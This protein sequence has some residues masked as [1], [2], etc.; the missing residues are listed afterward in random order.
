MKLCSKSQQN[1]PLQTPTMKKSLYIILFFSLVFTTEGFSVALTWVGIGSGGAGTNFN[2]AANWSP[3][4]V[5]T[6]ADAL[7]I[8]M[9]VGTNNIISLSGNIT[10][11]SLTMSVSGGRQGRLR[12]NGFLLTVN[13]AASFNAVNYTSPASYSFCEVDAGNAPGGFVFNGATQIHTTGSGDT[14]IGGATVSEGTMTFN[15]SL[16]MGPWAYTN[17]G[18][19]PIFAFDAVGAQTVTYRSNYHIK[20]SSMRFGVVNSPTVTIVAVAPGVAPNNFFTIYDGSVILNNNSL[21]DIGNF[22]FDPWVGGAGIQVNSTSTLQIGDNNNFPGFGVATANPTNYATYTISSVSR[23]SYVGGLAQSISNLAN[24]GYGHILFSGAGAKTSA[25]SFS[26]RGNWNN[27]TTF[28][29]N[30][31]THTFNGTPNQSIGG[32]VA[33]I[34]YNLIE[35]KA[36][37]S[38]LMAINNNQVNNV[39]TLTA[40]PLD[41]SGFTLIVNNAALAAVVRTAGYIISETNTAANA[42]IV[43][44]NMGVTTGAFVFP[45]GTTGAVYIPFTFNK[46]TATASNVSISTRPNVTSANTPWATGVTHMFSPTLAQDGSDEAV[47]DR[48]WHITSSAASTANLTFT[49]RGAENTMSV[50][51]NTGNVGAQYWG[52]AAWLPN[53]SNIG[54][55]PAVTAGTGSVTA[56]GVVFTA[57][58]FTPMVLSSTGAPL[59]VELVSF[60][61]TCIGDFA[62]L[63]WVTASETNNSHFDILRSDNGEPFHVVGTVDGN[64]TTSLSSE[65]KFIDEQSLGTSTMYRLVQYD[66][67]GDSKVFAPISV[68]SCATGNS[69]VHTYASNEELVVLIDSKAEGVFTVSIVDMQGRTV[70]AQQLTAGEGS[71][72]FGISKEGIVPGIYLV[73]TTLPNGEV[74][75]EK[76]FVQ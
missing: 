2:A 12:A 60:T 4:Q 65:Y 13:G 58:T 28:N 17:P 76:I 39:L 20:P 8:S 68:S 75:S 59:P 18:D 48:W 15:S 32:T 61:G 62:E 57:A 64:G 23:V 63:I 10:V 22:D 69:T 56:S 6:A 3:A 50:P 16:N 21:V 38:L 66:F 26:I 43:Q 14:Y 70:S 35:N 19:E 36:S 40:G 9:T 53:N 34:F 29:H 33:T 47:I 25:G 51:Y 5:P 45:F 52:S 24:P 49:Y 72:R 46:T 31:S 71:S 7:T 11:G 73:M 41:L 54:S 1:N 74:T 42:S 27:Q 55:A 37:G 30:N 67:N 44:W